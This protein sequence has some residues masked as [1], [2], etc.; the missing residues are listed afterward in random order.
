MN[1]K[2]TATAITSRTP[3][4][5]V[6]TAIVKPLRTP[7]ETGMLEAFAVSAALNDAARPVRE[8]AIARIAAAGLPGRRMEPWHY[9][10]LRTLLKTVSPVAVLESA[11]ALP[12]AL[13]IDGAPQI[14]F[15]GA[16]MS[17][18]GALPAGVTLASL[19]HDAPVSA[20]IPADEALVVLNTAFALASASL[21]IAPG[22]HAGAIHIAFRDAHEAAASLARRVRIEVQAGASVTIIE[23]HE[24]RNGLAHL[25]NTLIE[26]ELG[27]GAKVYHVRVNSCGDEANSLSTL[28]ACVGDNANFATL[29]MTTGARV[30]RHQIFVRY[31]GEHAHVALRGVSLLRGKQH[32]DTTLVIDHATPNC[33]SREAFKTIVDGDATGVFQGRIVVAPHAQKTDARMSSKAL[34]LSEGATMNNKPELEIF[35]DDVQCAHGATCGELDDNLLFYIMARGLPKREAEALLLEAFVGDVIV[36]VEDEALREVLMVK[37]RNWLAERT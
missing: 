34:L 4:E 17:A 22:T 19:A 12:G 5:I 1:S 23:S 11:T 15:S 2:R 18:S 6:M 16:R 9:T 37:A 24:S 13:V 21:V 31:A 14:V 7:A 33:E 35:A 3:R 36:E 29:S 10:D 25:T 32:A 8:A 27:D 28:A 20:A 26:F 30:S